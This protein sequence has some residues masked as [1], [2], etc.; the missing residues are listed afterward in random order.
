M[1]LADKNKICKYEYKDSSG[2]GDDE[3]IDVKGQVLKT[4]QDMLL[5]TN[6]PPTINV[7]GEDTYTPATA[8]STF[9][10]SRRNQYSEATL[11]VLWYPQKG[12]L[13]KTME[14]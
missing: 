3:K 1:V 13:N 9:Q 14:D 2:A 8:Q 10:L 6:V 5:T 12:S 7:R 4:E 11:L